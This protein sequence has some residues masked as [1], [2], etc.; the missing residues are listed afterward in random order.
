M[1]ECSCILIEAIRSLAWPSVV[2]FLAVY[3]GNSVKRVIDR[4]SKF[5][6]EGFGLRIYGVGITAGE[7]QN[8]QAKSHEQHGKQGDVASPSP[9]QLPAREDMVFAQIQA[10]LDSGVKDPDLDLFYG[11]FTHT[12]EIVRKALDSGASVTVTDTDV[13]RRYAKTLKLPETKE[14]INKIAMRRVKQ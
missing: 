7:L 11:V 9:L 14:L 8:S 5:E 6:A 1:S 13:L 10:L 3:F 12:A 2:I 4:L